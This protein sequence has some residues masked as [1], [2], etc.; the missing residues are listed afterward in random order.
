VR[1][2]RDLLSARVLS[3]CAG[4]GSSRRSQWLLCVHGGPLPAAAE[5]SKSDP[6]AH[7]LVAHGIFYNVKPVLFLLRGARFEIIDASRL[8]SAI[9][10]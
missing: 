3:L 8:F 6:P 7:C 5:L 1:V 10:S 4:T 2:G 9:H